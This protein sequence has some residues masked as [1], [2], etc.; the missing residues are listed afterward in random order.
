[1]V[2]KVGRRQDRLPHQ[3]SVPECQVHILLIE[4]AAVDVRQ[5]LSAAIGLTRAA[6]N[7]AVHIETH[8]EVEIPEIAADASLIL[9]VFV[10][11]ISNALDAMEDTVSGSLT[12]T[13]RVVNQNVE[14][15]FSDTGTGLREPDHV[16]DPFYTTKSVGKGSGLGLSTCY[17]RQHQGVI[18]CRNRE[19]GGA[20]FTVGLPIALG[21]L[22]PLGTANLA[23]VEGN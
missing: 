16:F 4:I 22:P 13:L 21:K 15:E 1:M 8:S 17:V 23:A 19:G 11:L 18:S 20:V 14:L 2:C 10:Q 6:R 5:V 3:Q 12:I 9:Q 7:A